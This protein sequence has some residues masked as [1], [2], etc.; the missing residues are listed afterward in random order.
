[1]LSCDN[2]REPSNLGRQPHHYDELTVIA[3]LRWCIY[4]GIERLTSRTGRRS[5]PCALRRSHQRSVTAI[6]SELRN[7]PSLRRRNGMRA[8][9]QS[10]AEAPPHAKCQGVRH[11]AERHKLEERRL[12]G[13][14]PARGMP[15]SQIEAHVGGAPTIAHK[16]L[17]FRPGA[18]LIESLLAFRP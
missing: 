17:P 14:M 3:I 7:E 5:G 13:P 9:L 16:W 8:R 4:S 1:M 12:S 11:A 6:P 10:L 2:R 18:G 15:C